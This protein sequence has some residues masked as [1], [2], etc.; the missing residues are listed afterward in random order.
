MTLTYVAV[1]SWIAAGCKLMKA[2]FQESNEDL[3]ASL[4]IYLAREPRVVDG[5]MHP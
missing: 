1:V 3:D 4:Y 2:G 5:I